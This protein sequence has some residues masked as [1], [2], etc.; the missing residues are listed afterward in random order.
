MAKKWYVKSSR[1]ITIT[2]KDLKPALSVT[3]ISPLDDLSQQPNNP[4][5][6]VATVTGASTPPT[7]W[8]V[9]ADGTR[10]NPSSMSQSGNDWT[11]NFGTAANPIPAGYYLLTVTATNPPNTASDTI[12]VLVKV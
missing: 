5:V 1:T 6:A 9:N 2:N 4:F 3:I 10:I 12:P 11:F 8:L 7:A